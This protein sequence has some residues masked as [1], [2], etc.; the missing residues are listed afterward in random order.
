MSKISTEEEKP[1]VVLAQDVSI[2]CADSEDSIYFATLS[3]QLSTNFNVVEYNYSEDV[4]KGFLS[5]K[6][7][8]STDISNLLDEV[9]LKY[10]GRNLLAIVASSDGLYNKG[11]NPFYHKLSK[12]VPIYSIAIGDTSVFKDVSITNVIHNDISFLDNIS[13]I[14]V[15][16]NTEKCKGE[17]LSIKLYSD[18]KLIQTNEEK[19]SK[20][21]DFIKTSF[22]L[23]NTKIGLQKYS[24]EVSGV[25]S[26]KY[27]E[28]N[29]FNFFI[30]VL[31][32]KYKILILSDL[33]HPDIGAFK[34]VLDNN[35]NYEV[36]LY[37]LSDFDSSYKEYNLI[38]TFYLEDNNSSKLVNLKDSGLPILMFVNSKSFSL[39]NSLYSVGKITAKNNVQEVTA[40][41]N[42]N[43]KKFNT[44]S[45]LQSYLSD[46]PP[47]ST[48]FG[49][50]SLSASSDVLAFQKIGI[51]E[52]NK[53]L[54]VLDET[55]ERKIAIVYGE[56][57]WRWRLN[58]RMDENFHQNFD[59][60]FSNISQY[61]LI[62][63]DKSRFRIDVNNKSEEG[64]N[65]SFKA[66]YYNENYELNN[67]KD[68]SLKIIKETG[69]EFD[70]IFSRNEK[71]SYFLNVKSLS[72]G[73][74]FYTANYNYSEFIKKGEFSVLPRSKE[75]VI[76]TAN[77]QFLYQLSNYSGGE[78]FT[79]FDIETLYQILLNSSRNK[80][81]IHSTEKTD[82]ILNNIWILFFILLL[83]STEWILRK[84]NGFY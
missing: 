5:D 10:S 51:L 48:V 34:S 80:I 16:I 35:K 11:S 1:I 62:K 73:K 14:E 4:S 12:S 26:E 68:V 17:I 25:K 79:N 84:Y 61:L 8:E 69:E 32:S 65:L 75:A 7:G 60:L 64:R 66:E 44:S 49:E 46:L 28:N 56:G 71:S 3:E 78:M 63:E 39:L 38:V 83:I 59:E 53:P 23:K 47:L 37:S 77:H 30:E 81:V 31:E 22:N 20:S 67:Q 70:Y 19:V 21:S 33:V 54:I 45:S 52:T 15:Q 2:S 40:S 41:Y 36:D 58:D 82:S 24:V 9:D 43:F 76:N 42:S 13:P 18:N 74:Y 6:K 57:I 55:T 50:Y 72:E 29:S 27:L